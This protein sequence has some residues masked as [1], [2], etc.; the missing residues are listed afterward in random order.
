M[1]NHKRKLS[2]F[3]SSPMTFKRIKLKG[4]YPSN[5]RYTPTQSYASRRKPPFSKVI[6]DLANKRKTIGRP[7]NFRCGGFLGIERKFYDTSNSSVVLSLGGNSTGGEVDPTGDITLNT[8]TQGDGES[9]RD[10][11]QICMKTMFINGIVTVPAQANQTAAD[12]APIVYIALVLDMQANGAKLNSEDVFINPSGV[13]TLGT[14]V[15]R[16]LQFIQ[17]FKVL[18]QLTIA[19]RQPE[20]VYDGTSA[21]MHGHHTPWSMFVNLKDLLVNYS[22]TTEVVA[23]ITDNA[24]SLV[25]FTT[26]TSLAP[27]LHYN[28]RL[29]FTG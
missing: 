9:Q 14:S 10:G 28:A 21:D 5:M 20:S 25:A 3:T 29:R 7:L 13:A 17:R 26:N 6:Q 15:F 27:T 11:R 16:N 24:L 19:I 23:N 1:P 4:R 12:L 18:K 2:T 8:V 22:G